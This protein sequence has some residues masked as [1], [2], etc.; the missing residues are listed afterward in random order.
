MKKYKTVFTITAT[1]D[2]SIL[3]DDIESCDLQ[4]AINQAVQMQSFNHKN[5]GTALIKVRCK[6]VIAAEVESD[7]Q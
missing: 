4:D 2:D 7:N 1:Q 6:N 3:L 5:S